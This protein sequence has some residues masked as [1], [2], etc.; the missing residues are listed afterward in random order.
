MCRLV[1]QI[2]VFDHRDLAIDQAE[3]A[4]FFHRAGFNQCLGTH[5]GLI[6]YMESDEP[7]IDNADERVV[8]LEV[9]D[10]VAPEFLDL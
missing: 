1:G 3:I 10:G 8:D 9:G 6:Q 2:A 7:P 4:H 5:F